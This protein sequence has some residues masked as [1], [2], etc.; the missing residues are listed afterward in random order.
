MLLSCWWIYYHANL[1]ESYKCPV[2]VWS[3]KTNAKRSKPGKARAG[4]L[5]FFS[6]SWLSNQPAGY[7]IVLSVYTLGISVSTQQVRYH[8]SNHLKKYTK[9]HCSGSPNIRSRESGAP[10]V[11]GPWTSA[12]HFY[13][14]FFLPLGGTLEAFGGIRNV[15]WCY[16]SGN[17]FWAS[18]RQCIDGDGQR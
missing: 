6:L 14:F 2:S 13:S 9:P 11:A 8:E 16:Q 3:L 1:G 17:L 5:G 15:L 18:P 4:I 10:V 12:C 7:L